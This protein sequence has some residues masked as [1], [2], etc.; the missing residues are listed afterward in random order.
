MFKIKI[1]ILFLIS[2]LL[3]SILMGCNDKVNFGKADKVI[4]SFI[5]AQVEGQKDIVNS[6]ISEDLK[7]KFTKDNLYFRDK[8]NLDKPNLSTTNIFEL[9]SNEKQKIIAANYVVEGQDEKLNITSLFYLEKEED[10]WIIKY[11]EEKALNKSLE[12]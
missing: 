2:I 8:Y 6:V 7:E 5:S 3:L 12:S 9:Q 10:K 11:I 4:A 1:K